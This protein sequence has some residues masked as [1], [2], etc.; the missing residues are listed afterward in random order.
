MIKFFNLMRLKMLNKKI[1]FLNFIKFLLGLALQ[2]Q[3]QQSHPWQGCQLHSTS[4]RKTYHYIVTKWF[5][6]VAKWV[7]TN[8]LENASNVVKW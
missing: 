2:L 7:E 4:N 6:N 5:A 3:L 1:I 8:W